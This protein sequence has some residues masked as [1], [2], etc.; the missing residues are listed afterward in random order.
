[1]I[2]ILNATNNPLTVM[3]G[4]AGICY[5]STNPK[6][7]PRIAKRCLAENHGRV[8]E[9]ADITIQISGYSAK[10][11]RE[12]YTH[13]SGTSRLQASTRYID[14][15]GQFKY[16]TPP[17]I[18]RNDE[19]MKVWAD[20]MENI[21]S[22]MKEL[23]DLDIPVEDL[24]NLLPLAYDTTMV[25]KINVRSLIHMMNVRLCTC[26]YH[27]YRLLMNDLKKEIYKLDDEWKFLCD[28]YFVP[29][30][31]ATG[32]CEETTRSCGLRPLKELA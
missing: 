5:G 10:V 11:I 13:I 32:Y 15:S 8:S 21:N 9:F 30:C 17:S 16:I 20:V 3:G 28:N 4:V 2:K 22:G 1:M 26:A 18:V 7:F 6:S 29:K 27:E 14:Y 12:L 19:A 24:T 31:V 25:L 23:K